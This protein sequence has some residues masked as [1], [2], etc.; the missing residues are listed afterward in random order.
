[1]DINGKSVLI[2]GGASGIGE[3]CARR[4]ARAG[5]KV[6]VLDM[7]K[8]DGERVASEIGGV[9]FETNVTDEDQVQRAVDGAAEA[10]GGIHVCLNVAGVGSAEKTYGKNGPASLEGFARVLQINLVGTFNVARLAAEKM[11]GQEPLSEDGQRGV[12]VNTA[13]VAAYEGQVGQA[14][15]AAS[16][17]G[18]VGMTLPMARDLASLGI[19]V[20]TIA[21]GLVHTPLFEGLR[22]TSPEMFE[23]LSGSVLNPRRLAQPD[24]IAQAAQFIAEN[25]YVNGETIRVDGGIRMQPR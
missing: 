20:C 13:S 8:D 12:I 17:G 16:K 4:F 6:A 18:V 11:A 7:T 10:H 1:M 25:D 19:R 14:A 24:E 5:A 3:A 9:F 21:P 22:E 2:T 15:Y 23:R